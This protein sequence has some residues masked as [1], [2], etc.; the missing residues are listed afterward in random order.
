MR[1]FLAANHLRFAPHGKTTMSP[2]L[3]A[4]QMDDGAWALTLATVQQMR[5]ARAA[6]IA[7][8]VLAN[9]LI[10][11]ADIAYVL[12][13]MRSDPGFEFYCLVDSHEGVRRLAE[14]AHAQPPGRPLRVLIELGQSGGRAGLRTVESALALA[15][16]IKAA[17]P[18]L[19]LCGV[20][21]FEGLSQHLPETEAVPRVRALLQAI[22]SAATIIDENGLF[23]G[24]EILLSAGGSAFY[25]LVAETLGCGGFRKPSF[26]VL[27]SGCYLTHDA[28][29]YQR[30][31]SE[32]A[33]RSPRACAGGAFENALEVWCYVLSVP[34][35]SRAIL[36]AG[37]RDFGH[38]AAPPIPLKHFRT[39]RDLAPAPAG[40][41]IASINDQH[42]HMMVPP[43]A[44]VNV[45]DAIGLGVSHPCTTFDKWRLLYVVDDAYVVQSG[46][47][48]F[49]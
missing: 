8:I 18:L 33:Q 17:N 47:Q 45:G 34:E 20:E 30:S 40:W 44:D 37:R 5:V 46:V 29:L 26:V 36:G 11:S 6:G 43:G 28:G 3:F 23:S 22:L 13:E 10:A 27:R 14:A 48:T 21:G 7:R 32:I 1:E 9:E 24:E 19:S 12:E 2:E 35:P 49:F 42:A 38:D 41:T 25:D 15:R 31:F 16:E 39:G 4:L